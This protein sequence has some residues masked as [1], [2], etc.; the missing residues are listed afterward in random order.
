[1]RFDDLDA[2]C[3]LIAEAVRK[4]AER[5]NELCGIL[6]KIRFK[7]LFSNLTPPLRSGIR[8][9]ALSIPVTPT[10]LVGLHI[11]GVDGGL[12]SNQLQYLDVVLTRAVGVIFRYHQYSKIAVEQLVSHESSPEITVKTEALSRGE[13]EALSSIRRAITEI[14]LARKAVEQKSINVLLL[15]G[16][17]LPQKADRPVADSPVVEEYQTMLKCYQQFYE[18]CEERGVLAFGCIKD[19]KATQFRE[20]FTR[21]LPTIIQHCRRELAP[22]LTVDYRHILLGMFDSELFY[23][24]LAP[25]ERSCCFPIEETPTNPEAGQGPDHPIYCF[26]LKTVAR[27]FPLR[28]EFLAGHENPQLRADR[29]A[30]VVYPLSSHH[31]EYGLPSV[32][33]EA[34]ARAR[35]HQVD[36]DL[37]VEN[38]RT[39]IGTPDPWLMRRERSIFYF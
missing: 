8:D 11:A 3:T 24:L 38:I 39:R 12:V 15:D 2:K 19:S 27:D 25:R 30:S 10:E 20:T 4:I 14:D 1:M 31:A 9:A 17:I 34:D 33:I 29:I 26:Y 22:L 18:A 21:A 6:K 7:A 5:R 16:S 28:I 35:L 37:I 32:L 36:L 13:F 23:R